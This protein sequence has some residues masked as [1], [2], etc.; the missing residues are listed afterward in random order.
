MQGWYEKIPIFDQHLALSRIIRA[1][2]IERKKHFV[3]VYAIFIPFI[4]GFNA[5][6][7]VD[8]ELNATAV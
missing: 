4:G 6:V 7:A 3:Y 2:H 1:V 5:D 8:V